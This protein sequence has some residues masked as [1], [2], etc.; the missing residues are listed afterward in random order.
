MLCSRDTSPQ[1]GVD[2]F[3]LNLPSK[4][5]FQPLI[6]IIVY[7]KSLNIIRQN[8]VCFAF[9]FYVNWATYVRRI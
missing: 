2:A 8:D 1:I 4:K 5:I 7:F 6:D 3:F 9:V